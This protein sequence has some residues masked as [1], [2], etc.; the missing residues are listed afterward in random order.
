VTNAQYRE[1]M[2]ARPGVREPEHWGD[3]Q[4]NQDDQPVVGVSWHE[5]QA[6]CEWAGLVLPTEAQW[7]HA[8]R[9]GTTTRYHSG[10][11]EED[12]SR[13]GWYGG[14][15]DSRLHAVGEKE[16]NAWGLHDMHGNVWEWCRDAH[17]PYTTSARK[18][19]GLR[20]EPEG[21]ADRVIRGG[22]WSYDAR[23]ARAACRSRL[24]P[25]YRNEHV[26][27]RPAQV[28]PSSFTPSPRPS[29]GKA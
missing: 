20:R 27:F 16:A 19:D 12:L 4:L 29:A 8:C 10:D 28:I 3:R 18:S 7:E 13:V 23:S 14:N 11:A 24:H 6:Y 5:A 22:G 2:K 21:D 1:Y 17:E 25:D 15:S 26:G 9:A